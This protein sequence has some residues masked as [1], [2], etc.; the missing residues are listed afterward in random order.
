MPSDRKAV[1]A[2][3]GMGPFTRLWC[4]HV[5]SL[6]G[7]SALRFAFI[8]QAWTNSERATPVVLLSLCAVVPEILLSPVAGALIDRVSK[9]TALQFADLGGLTVVAVLGLLQLVATLH[10]WQIYVTVALLGACAAFQNPAL[11]SAVP[12]LV[13]KDQYQ[14]ANGLI[15]SARTGS[16]ICGPALG[17]LVIALSGIGTI[18]W[19]DLASFVVALTV[20]RVTRFGATDTGD[21]ADTGAVA[22]SDDAAASA[23]TSTSTHADAGESEAPPRRGILAESLDG[24]RVLFTRPGLRALVVVSSAANLV[25][26][27]GF[28]VIPPMVLARSGGSS[29]TLAAVTTC[30][31]VGGLGGGLMTAAWGGPRRRAR[32]MMLGI[33]GMCV[34]AQIGMAAAHSA[35]GWCTAILLGALLMPVVNSSFQSILQAEVEERLQGRVFGAEAFLSDLSVPVAMG[36]SGPLADRVFEPQARTHSG[37][38]GVLAPVVGEGRGS[39]MAALLLLAGVC[40]VVV[41]LWGLARR[42]VRALDAAGADDA[43]GDMAVPV[44][45]EKAPQH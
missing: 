32:G 16:E 23:D 25:M 17:G 13:R 37:V 41:A 20:V 31:G 21:A 14:R 4:G 18:I 36:I 38:T 34:S 22:A 15:S 1:R 39:G 26:V 33:V 8:V 27:T 7:N 10:T 5:V 6:V 28:A 40:G 42:P 19:L 2:F 44:K 24:L 43:S 11:L 12:L 35:L 3:S 9:R 29:G 30:M 45:N